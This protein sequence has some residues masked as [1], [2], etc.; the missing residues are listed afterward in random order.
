MQGTR[1]G[2]GRLDWWIGRA[3]SQF[4]PWSEREGSAAEARPLR[5]PEKLRH[6]CLIDRPTPP[7]PRR[8]SSITE[9]IGTPRYAATPARSMLKSSRRWM[10][11]IFSDRVNLRCCGSVADVRNLSTIR[12][13]SLIRAYRVSR[14]DRSAFGGRLTTR[15]DGQV[16][17]RRSSPSI[18]DGPGSTRRGGAGGERRAGGHGAAGAAGDSVGPA[19]PVTAPDLVRASCALIVSLL[20]P[21]RR[22]EVERGNSEARASVAPK[23]NRKAFSEG[24]RPR[25]GVETDLP[26][27]APA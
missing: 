17:R 15:R 2:F 8:Q 6:A 14:G 10:D 13:I 21:R 1:A 12:Q 9:S 25:R 11:A 26:A 20:H 3:S 4:L 22:G 16:S 24:K 27:R 7:S 5:I 23:L 18:R 19:G